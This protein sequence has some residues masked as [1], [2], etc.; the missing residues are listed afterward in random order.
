MRQVIN[1]PAPNA[2]LPMPFTVPNYFSAEDLSESGPLSTVYCSGRW[3]DLEKLAAELNWQRGPFPN[4]VQAALYGA[5]LVHEIRPGTLHA[6][7]CWGEMYFP[8]EKRDPL[9]FKTYECAMA[10][11][12]ARYW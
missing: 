12:L 10:F 5:I 7:P 11:I 1:I 4:T 2:A 6:S 3:M 9:V 8:N